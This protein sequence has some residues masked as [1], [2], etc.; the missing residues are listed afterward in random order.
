MVQERSCVH[1]SVLVDVWLDSIALAC[2]QGGTDPL[3]LAAPERYRVMRRLK[4]YSWTDNIVYRIMEDGTRRIVPSPADRKAIVKTMHAAAGHF[5]RRRTTHLLMLSHWWA[6]L[7][8][9]VRDVVRSCQSCDRTKVSFNSMQPVLNPLPIRGLLYS[10]G[11]DLAGPYPDSERGNRYVL[12]CIEHFSKYLEVFPLRDKSS[13]E[14]AYHFAH[15]II[16][17]YGACAEV[18]SD[19]GGEFE[20]AF[21]D[22]LCRCLIDHR[23]TS[24]SHPQANGASE[25]LVQT[26]KASISR[27]VD[28]AADAVQW[29]TFLPWIAL[30][31]RVTP[32]AS[33]KLSPYHILFAVP[34]VVPPCVKER[35]SPPLDFDDPEIAIAS[36][37]ERA[38]IIQQAC[39]M[40]GHNLLI[41]QQRDKLRYAKLRSGG[42]LPSIVSFREGDFVY[43]KDSA[44]PLHDMARPDIYRVLVSRPSGVLVLVGPDGIPGGTVVENAVNCSPCHL[45]ISDLITPLSDTAMLKPS[46]D[47]HCQT[48]KLPDME[49]QLLLCDSCHQGYHLS[50][51]RPPLLKVP[52]GFWLCQPC[53][54]AGVDPST[55]RTA[56]ADYQFRRIERKSKLTAARITPRIVPPVVPPTAATGRTGTRRSARLLTSAVTG[57]SVLSDIDWA[58]PAASLQAMRTLM[59]GPW[60]LQN[61]LYLTDRRFGGP[62][63]SSLFERTYSWEVDFLRQLI[64]FSVPSSIIDLCSGRGDIALSLAS[65][66]CCPSDGVSRLIDRNE[67]D[68][69]FPADFHLDPMQP[70]TYTVLQEFHGLDVVIM[71]PCLAV[72]DVVLPLSTQ[73]ARHLVCCRLPLAYI[74]DAHIARRT[75]LSAMHQ[76]GR[77]H[78][79]AIT[80]TPGIVARRRGQIWLLIFTSAEARQLLLRSGHSPSLDLHFCP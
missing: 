3:S 74:F 11:V 66:P 55:L 12:V 1:D 21:S 62:A 16:S 23:V 37:L 75:W 24:A 38:E 33:S 63:C 54:K 48:C 4:R 56:R 53:L 51:L 34:P 30:G 52:S 25:R 61:V 41:A 44:N 71:S 59:P 43:V 9:D 8:R 39:T 28:T 2:L 67:V 35:L 64:D 32:Q 42:Y 77:L 65:L 46:K 22:L 18:V 19:G 5:G 31:Y 45:P 17:R 72:A 69:S 26:I 15:G 13:A 14:V 70:S 27:Y 60:I 73:A 10:W 76:Q 36:I 68:P 80:I 7:Y 58:S 6:G 20:G 50:C 40:A 57:A 79:L 47:L 49:S 78:L 29:D